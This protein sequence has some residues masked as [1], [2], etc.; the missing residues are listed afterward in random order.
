MDFLMLGVP[1]FQSETPQEWKAY[2]LDFTVL[3]LTVQP[4]DS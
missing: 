3:S 1:E 4:S 2:E